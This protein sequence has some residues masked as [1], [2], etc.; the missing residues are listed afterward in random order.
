MKSWKLPGELK[1]GEKCRGDV[2]LKQPHSVVPN[3]HI[4]LEL[5]CVVGDCTS[6]PGL[7]FLFLRFNYVV[8]QS[9]DSFFF[10]YNA[11]ILFNSAEG[12]L[13]CF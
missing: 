2:Y 7:F 4:H 10:Y 11:G 8:P 13:H 3:I 6:C 12:Y 5:S 1:L 9:I